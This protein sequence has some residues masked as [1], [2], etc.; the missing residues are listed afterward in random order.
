M[1]FYERYTI[2]LSLSSKDE[3]TAD[4]LKRMSVGGRVAHQI[5]VIM[6]EWSPGPVKVLPTLEMVLK[7]KDD[8]PDA[9]SALE[10]QALRE[11]NLPDLS[12][13]PSPV[14]EDYEQP[15]TEPAGTK[16]A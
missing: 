16:A 1:A 13:A 7:H 8:H 10:T 9:Y 14:A 6:S 4:V 2:D 5:A 15:Q 11:L 3:T 12:L